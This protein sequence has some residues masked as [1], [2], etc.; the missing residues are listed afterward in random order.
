MTTPY[1]RQKCPHV[2]YN[3]L[4]ICCSDCKRERLTRSKK[5]KKNLK[6]LHQQYLEFCY[7]HQ[8]DD[9]DDRC[10]LWRPMDRI[11]EYDDEGRDFF[12]YMCNS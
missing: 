6:T 1:N 11:Q 8:Y 5:V 3:K 9:F 2:K 7:F 10:K 12:T 4:K